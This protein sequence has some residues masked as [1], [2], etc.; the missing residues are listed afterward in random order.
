MIFFTNKVECSYLTIINQYF[1]G[2]MNAGKL[3]L[4]KPH[5]K[6]FRVS[7]SVKNFCAVETQPI[8]MRNQHLYQSPAI[9]MSMDTADYYYPDWGCLVD[10]FANQ[11]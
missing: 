10:I 7:L 1:F 3:Y 4:E 9:D 8:L 11:S 6:I 5:F 2:E